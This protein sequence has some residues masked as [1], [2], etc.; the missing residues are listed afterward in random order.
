MFEK[1]QNI[2]SKSKFMSY[3]RFN[4]NKQVYPEIR[5]IGIK[6]GFVK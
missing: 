1:F 5:L 6:G 3:I 2:L 4:R